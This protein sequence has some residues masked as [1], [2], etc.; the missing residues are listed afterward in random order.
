[1]V[2]GIKVLFKWRLESFGIES[3]I[4]ILISR[5]VDL[6]IVQLALLISLSLLLLLLLKQ[7]HETGSIG[8]CQSDGVLMKQLNKQSLIVS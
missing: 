5:S 2:D 8:A 6:L 1:M 4:D 3:L 7:R